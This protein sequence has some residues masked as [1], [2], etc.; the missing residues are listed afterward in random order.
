MSRECGRPCSRAACHP[1]DIARHYIWDQ[2]DGQDILREIYYWGIYMRLRKTS[3]W[4]AENVGDHVARQPAILVTLQ[5]ITYW[6]LRYI[7]IHREI[8]T[9]INIWGW[10][11]QASD[12]LRVGE[13]IKPS[14]WH[15]EAFNMRNVN[16]TLYVQWQKDTSSHISK[17][18]FAQSQ[19]HPV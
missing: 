2:W 14:F 12:E 6:I 11:R 13:T 18:I 5:G 9:E 15:C 16:C 1:C 8:F 7:E 10:E 4:W 3:F 19:T 17:T